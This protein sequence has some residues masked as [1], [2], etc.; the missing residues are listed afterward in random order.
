MRAGRLLVLNGGEHLLPL[1]SVK[2]EDIGFLNAT[3]FML[4]EVLNV[5]TLLSVL[6]DLELRSL[7]RVRVTS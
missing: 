1:Q 6:F 5:N 4:D 3:S 2:H 7:G